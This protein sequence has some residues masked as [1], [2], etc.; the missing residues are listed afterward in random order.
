MTF[1]PSIDVP[2]RSLRRLKRRLRASSTEEKNERALYLEIVFQ[3][4]SSAGAMSFISVFLVRLGA[5][6][7][8]VGLYTS[9]PALMTM[10]AIIPMSTFVQ[11]QRSLVATASWGR[12][13]FRGVIGMFALLPFLP[14]SISPFVLVAARGLV[15]IP[16]CAINISITTILGSVTTAQRRPRMLSVRM[17]INGLVSAAVGFGAGQWLERMPYPLNYQLLFTTAF[18]AGLGSV[19][20]LSRLDI[21]E[22]SEKEIRQRKRVGL[23]DIIPLIKSTPAFRDYSIAAFL[24]RFGMSFPMALYSIYRVRTLGSSDAWIGILL[25]VQRLLSVLAYFTLSRLLARK[26]FR[27]WLWVTC[28]LMALF[29]LTTALAHTPEMLL[30]PAAI[31]GLF[32]AGK[33]IFFTNTLFQV[34]PEEQRPTFVA[35]NTFMA[36]FT[37][38]VAPLL[39]T[40]LAEVTTIRA[41]LLTAAVIRAGGGLVFWW[42]GVGRGAE[43]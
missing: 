23:R 35:A 7:W 18:V 39:G 21:P 27:Q 2:S 20:A 8:L 31:G 3:A 15:S 1:P 43:S 40:M 38:F 37:S 13:L 14:P 12:I 26:K 6:A 9:L 11:R 41:A 17:A 16:G 33:N 32:G 36:N 4:L 19:W 28:F 10:L 22:A 42:L 25:T 29:P 34:S 5:P 30:I 24:M